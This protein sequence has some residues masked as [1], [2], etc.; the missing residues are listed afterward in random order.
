MILLM[1]N[2]KLKIVKT[3]AKNPIVKKVGEA[4]VERAIKTIAGGKVGRPRTK[5]VKKVIKKR[6]GGGA[7]YPAGGALYPAGTRK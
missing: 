3:V 1:R 5:V 4:L 6:I 7:L 2:R